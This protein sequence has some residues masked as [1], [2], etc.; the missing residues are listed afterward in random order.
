MIFT[1]CQGCVAGSDGSLCTHVL[2]LLLLLEKYCA[3]KLP[4][5]LLLCSRRL[6]GQNAKPEPAANLIVESPRLDRD[7]LGEP[8][9]SMLFEAHGRNRR[10]MPEEK[11]D[12]LWDSLQEGCLMKTVLSSVEG[13]NDNFPKCSLQT[14]VFDEMTKCGPT[15]QDITCT[16]CMRNARYEGN[17]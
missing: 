4:P 11:V 17:M 13:K 3:S 12:E 5:A 14:T 10:E 2:A 16:H 6:R 7:H 8:I 9:S 1:Q 15:S